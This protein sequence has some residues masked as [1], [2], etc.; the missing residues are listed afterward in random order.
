MSPIRA[1]FKLQGCRPPCPPPG[2]LMS[3]GPSVSQGL[4]EG[5]HI[6]P[7]SNAPGYPTPRSIHAPSRPR[8]H[9][10]PHQH[11]RH[12]LGPRRAQRQRRFR[13]LVGGHV[14][15]FLEEFEALVLAWSRLH[16]V[17]WHGGA[18]AG[19][20][21][22]AADVVADLEACGIPFSG[23]LGSYEVATDYAGPIKGLRSGRTVTFDT[24]TC[25]GASGHAGETYFAGVQAQGTQA[26]IL[27]GRTAS[28]AHA[29]P[30]A[31][32]V[33]AG[34]IPAGIVAPVF[35]LGKR[36][37]GKAGY[38]AV[39]YSAAKSGSGVSARE[40]VEHSLGDAP[41]VKWTSVPALVA[42]WKAAGSPECVYNA[43]TIGKGGV[44]A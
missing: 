17:T 44:V 8:F 6:I 36:R 5:A 35:A 15:A 29:A 37:D 10:L 18:H 24:L 25:Y 12:P 43:A 21:Y 14:P 38:C 30:V 31:R 9:R 22:N 27:G 34:S 33:R 32:A 19:G 1:S 28:F 13:A 26:V 2:E 23:I 42:L 11:P 20:T 4:H 41:S 39:A 40:A 3:G 16:G 7:R